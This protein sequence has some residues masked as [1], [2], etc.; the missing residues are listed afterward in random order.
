M[1][2]ETCD[3]C[4]WDFYL[5]PRPPIRTDLKCEGWIGFTYSHYDRKCQLG[6]TVAGL[7]LGESYGV[8]VLCI[9]VLFHSMELGHHQEAIIKKNSTL[10]LTYYGVHYL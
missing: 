9:Y 6:V 5:V 1:Y 10:V 2:G 4:R 8:G 7:G 3:Q